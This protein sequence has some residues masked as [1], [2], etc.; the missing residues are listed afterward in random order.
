MS[1][2][3]DRPLPAALP[4]HHT[5]VAEVTAGLDGV[6][7]VTTMLRGRRYRVRDLTVDVHEGARASELR[8]TV[9]LTADEAALL[10][11]RLRRM[12]AV[13]AARTV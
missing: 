4:L 8:T 9:L 3:L 13:L 2:T 11:E 5:V 10:L 6:L 1:D 7:R 12:P